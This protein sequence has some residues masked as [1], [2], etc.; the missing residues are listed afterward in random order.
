LRLDDPVITR[1]TLLP[2]RGL[3]EDEAFEEVPGVGHWI[4]EQ[5]PEL[6]LDRLRQLMQL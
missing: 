2:L 1:T 5:A 4:I 3:S 6:V